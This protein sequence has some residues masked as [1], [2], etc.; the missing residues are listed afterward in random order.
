MVYESILALKNPGLF[1]WLNLFLAI[2][3]D[4]I[5]LAFVFFSLFFNLTIKGMIDE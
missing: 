3:L 2:I 5:I 1:E 4:F